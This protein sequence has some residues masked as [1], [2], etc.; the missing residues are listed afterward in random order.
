MNKCLWV[1]LLG[2]LMGVLSILTAMWIAGVEVNLK[3]ERK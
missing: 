2:E 3:K 1:L